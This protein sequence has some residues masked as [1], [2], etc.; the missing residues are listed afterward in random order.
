ME[1]TSDPRSGE[2]NGN[3]N[4]SN[5]KH[6]YSEPLAGPHKPGLSTTTTTSPADPDPDPDPDLIDDASP[7]T[8]PP[9]W[10]LTHPR[11]FS[12]ISV[13]PLQA[14]AIT[15]QDNTDEGDPKNKAC[16]ARSVY[17]QD[18]VIVNASR[19]NIG[20]FVV[21]NINVDTLQGGSMRIRKRFS[22]FD[23]LRDKLLQTFPNSKAAMPPLPPKSVISK[24]RP[25]F[26]ENRRSGL[27]YFLNCILLN[28]EFSGSPVLKEFLFS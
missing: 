15:L 12:N 28:P 13:E 20:A 27:Q 19:T 1:A 3:G 6:N 26:L 2:S 11:S 5:N 17:I 8:S 7:V 14:G 16:W 24:F 4:V 10:V 18:Y 9:Y 23:D 21:W 22:E 25:K